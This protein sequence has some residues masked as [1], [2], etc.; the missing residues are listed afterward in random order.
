MDDLLIEV[1]NPSGHFSSSRLPRRL[2]TRITGR[3][4]TM[5]ATQLESYETQWAKNTQ[6]T[7]AHKLIIIIPHKVEGR[8]KKGIHCAKFS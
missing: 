1:V 4:Q 8:K 6:S 2:V 3:C 7:L 5:I